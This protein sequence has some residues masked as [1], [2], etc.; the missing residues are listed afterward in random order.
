MFTLVPTC[1]HQISL[2]SCDSV[3]LKFEFQGGPARGCEGE[4]ECLIS[5][6]CNDNI[7]DMKHGTPGT[8]QGVVFS[9]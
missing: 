8:R 5:S 3:D 1:S 7:Q 4:F 2:P 9:I 6:H